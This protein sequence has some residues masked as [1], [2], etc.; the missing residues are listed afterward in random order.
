VSILYS[1]QKTTSSGVDFLEFGSACKRETSQR[2]RQP[3]QRKAR[4][5]VPC[6]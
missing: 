3:V 6:C 5:H 4:I 2:G 1:S